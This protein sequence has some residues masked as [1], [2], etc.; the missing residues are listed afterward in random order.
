MKS[1]IAPSAPGFTAGML[2]AHDAKTT[3]EA[4]T[5]YAKPVWIDPSK[6]KIEPPDPSSESSSEILSE[7]DAEAMAPRTPGARGSQPGGEL[8]PESAGESPGLKGK[9]ED[10]DE[11]AKKTG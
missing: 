5:W 10:A 4:A 7:P 11:K 6:G 2:R 8:S 1:S 9:A 3:Q